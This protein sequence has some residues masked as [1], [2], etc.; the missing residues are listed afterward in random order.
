MVCLNY[1]LELYVLIIAI[2]LHQ[3]NFVVAESSGILLGFL[4]RVALPHS[5]NKPSWRLFYCLFWGIAFLLFLIGKSIWVVF[6]Q[7]M[8]CY[9]IMKH[10]PQRYMSMLVFFFALGYMLVNYLIRI[11][12]DTP[13]YDETYPLMVTTQKLTSLAFGLSDWRLMQKGKKM[14][15]EREKWAVREMPNL[16]EY[17]AFVVS[18]QGVLAGPFCHW[19]LYRAFIEGN[20]KARLSEDTRHPVRYEDDPSTVGRA[21]AT[22]V[23][24]VAF[25]TYIQTS[26]HPLFP[27]AL[28]ADP[29]F[30]AK[31]NIFYRAFHAYLTFFIQRSK[32]YVTWI[33]ETLLTNNTTSFDFS[34]LAIRTLVADAVY[35]ASGLGYIGDDE[36]G[37]P[38]WT[39][40]T[41]VHVVKIET[42]PCLKIYLDNWNIMTTHWLRHVCYMRA[43]FLNT[44]FTFILSALWHG[45]HPGY[46][47]TFI[48]ASFFVQAGRKA[49]ANIRP[50]FQGSQT[51]RFVYD[52]ITTLATQVSLPH[53]VFSF[54]V[55]DSQQ[56]LRFHKSFYFGTYIIVACLCIFLPQH[57]QK[58]RPTSP[59]AS[60]EKELP[61]AAKSDNDRDN[62]HQQN[63]HTHQNGNHNNPGGHTE[64]VAAGDMASH[65]EGLQRRGVEL[66]Q[67]A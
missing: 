18:F 57:K 20:T 13:F 43:P 3:L 49:R 51:S 29:D 41:N 47:I 59:P 66:V 67:K 6:L 36:N 14:T 8:V 31:H 38:Q 48:A 35:N 11:N 32:Y 60:P 56:I 65:S 4:L 40:M 61:P 21:V 52:V 19:N 30:I 23:I 15:P 53:L 12:L 5:I 2:F 46:Y 42:A 7:I 58:R 63:H 64:V 1:T 25:W 33:L 22:K 9:F 27:R 44:L 26:M 10:G 45:V 54:V 16:L 50:L 55:R 62:N 17:L 37:Q 28:D 39:G 34:S 24:A